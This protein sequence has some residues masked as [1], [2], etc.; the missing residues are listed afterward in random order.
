MPTTVTNAPTTISI[1]LSSIFPSPPNIFLRNNYEI[2]L[3]I[4]FAVVTVKLNLIISTLTPHNSPDNK[5]H[6]SL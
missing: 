3:F 1:I 6:M 5:L 2:L 4:L